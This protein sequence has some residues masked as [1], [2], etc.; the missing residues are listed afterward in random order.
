MRGENLYQVDE[1]G[2]PTTSVVVYFDDEDNLLTE[3]DKDVIKVIIPQE[4][5]RPR[6]NGSEWIEDMTQEEIDE[7]Y[8]PQPKELTEIEKLKISQ[9][10]QFETILELLGGM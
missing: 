1:N 7:L 9:A 5:Y 6:W 2:F 10:E 8:K 4:L 3:V